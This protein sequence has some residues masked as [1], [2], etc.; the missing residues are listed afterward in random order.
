MDLLAAFFF[1]AFVIKHLKKKEPK[2][3]LSIFLK[4]SLVGA[5]LL[6]AVY[7]ILVL[8]GSIYAEQLHNVPPQE[9]L[10]FVANIAL[11]AWAA[12][13]ICVTVA[14][15]C[16]TTAIVL[17]SL[18]ADFLRKEITGD[19]INKLAAIM[20]TLLI[21]F[22]TSTLEFAGIARI[23]GPTLEVL[24]P[25]LILLTVVSLSNKLFLKTT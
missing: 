11:G 9:M 19:R 5:G 4:A 24:Y 10:G 21:A 15:A 13:I 7:V 16:L 22:F 17:T 20:T 8:L 3:S 2:E 1:S 12:P 6:S 23:L 14:L 25:V 18:F